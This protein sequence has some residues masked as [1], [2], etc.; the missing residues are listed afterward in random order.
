MSLFFKRILYPQMIL[1][2][3]KI[4]RDIFEEKPEILHQKTCTKENNK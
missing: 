4:K 1:F 3:Q 2:K